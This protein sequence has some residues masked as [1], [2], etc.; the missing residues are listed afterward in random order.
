MDN[1]TEIEP[2]P[3]PV[4]TNEL[5]NEIAVQF[6]AFSKEIRTLA[7]LWLLASYFDN[8]FNPIKK[9]RYTLKKMLAAI[10]IGDRQRFLLLLRGIA[11][12]QFRPL[13][14][15]RLAELPDKIREN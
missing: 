11:H 4:D 12:P 8:K 2:W 6:A 10:P 15:Q 3:E 7:P 13:L 1:R 5:V 14:D 9:Q